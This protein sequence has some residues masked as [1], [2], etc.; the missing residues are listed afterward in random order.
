MSASATQ[1]GINKLEIFRKNSKP[2]IQG[3]VSLVVFTARRSCACAVVGVVILS[4]RPSVR[5][6]VSRTRAL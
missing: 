1:G 4:V 5:L 3:N 6:F 2:A